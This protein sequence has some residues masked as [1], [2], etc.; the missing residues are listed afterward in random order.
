MRKRCLILAI[1]ALAAPLTLIGIAIAAAPWFSFWGNA[2][3]DLGHQVKHPDTAKI[4]NTGLILGTI[5]S[6][7][8]ACKCLRGW[9]EALVW[10]EGFSLA[11]VAV[12]NEA[13]GALHFWVSVLFFLSLLALIIAYIA[14]AE[15]IALKAYAAVALASYIAIWYMHFVKDVPPGA[16]IPELVSVALYAPIFMHA[17]ISE[18]QT[19]GMAKRTSYRDYFKSPK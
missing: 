8:L 3:S 11:L 19:R 10:L 13:Y 4:F 17:A 6:S 18:N 2:L 1:L 5:F 14:R 15:N 12:F 16:A 9:R 7:L